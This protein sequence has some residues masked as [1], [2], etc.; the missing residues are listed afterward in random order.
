M[1]ALEGRAYR[2]RPACATSHAAKD[3]HEAN[4]CIYVATG[5]I[6]EGARKFAREKKI[7][8]MHGVELAKLLPRAGRAVRAA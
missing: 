2:C 3:A 7:R 6:T 8:L 5:E 1:Q 4:E